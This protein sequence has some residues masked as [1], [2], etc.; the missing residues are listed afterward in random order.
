[1]FARWIWN[2]ERVLWFV[3]EA[4]SGAFVLEKKKEIGNKFNKFLMRQH[5][6]VPNSTIHNKNTHNQQ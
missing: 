3:C 2:S 4:F 6:L 5:S 1:V